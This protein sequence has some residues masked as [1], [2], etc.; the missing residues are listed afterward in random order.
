MQG[1]NIT[2]YSKWN[3]SF[4]I[5]LGWFLTMWYVRPAKAQTSMRVRSV[6][7][8]PLLVAWIF[9]ECWATDRTSFGVTKLTRRL[10]RIIRVYTCQ[11]TTLLEITCRGSNKVF[12]WGGPYS[13]QYFNILLTGTEYITILKHFITN[14]G[15][16]H[17]LWWS[18]WLKN[19]TDSSCI[20]FHKKLSLQI[21]C[22]K[23]FFTRMIDSILCNI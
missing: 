5:F 1:W 15:G 23:V 10:H 16:V 18:M 8:E 6:W 21:A 14:V 13:N 22:S 19:R 11:N 2:S 17:K 9:Y 20:G 3:W 4:I 12:W 7:S